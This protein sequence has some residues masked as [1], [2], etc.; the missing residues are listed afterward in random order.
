[1]AWG[2]CH[3]DCHLLSGP[4]NPEGGPEWL[5]TSPTTQWQ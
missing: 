3:L 2:R 4:P 1:V 5:F